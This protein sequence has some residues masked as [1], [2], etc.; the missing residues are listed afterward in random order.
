MLPL[1]DASCDVAWSQDSILHAGNRSRVFDEVDRVLKL[2]EMADPVIETGA[3][4]S[5]AK[6]RWPICKARCPHRA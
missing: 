3:V 2:V 5:V 6:A 4:S 1:P